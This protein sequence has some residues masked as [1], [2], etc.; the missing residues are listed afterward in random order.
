MGHSL[1]KEEQA[2]VKLLQHILSKRGLQYD[3]AALQRLLKWS[4]DRGFIPTVQAAF[5]ISE[6]ERIGQALSD[7]ISK[8]T[9]DVQN[10]STL[11]R[12]MLETLKEMKSERTAMASVLMATAPSSEQSGSGA[13]ATAMAFAPP[14]VPGT[15]LKH[16]TQTTGKG[17]LR[18]HLQNASQTTEV[19]ARAPDPEERDPESELDPGPDSP[20]AE[21]DLYPPLSDS[22][23]ESDQ[24]I[25]SAHQQLVAGSG[26][27]HQSILQRLAA[28]EAGSKVAGTSAPP[29]SKSFLK[30]GLVGMGPWDPLGVIIRHIVGSAYILTPYDIRLLAQ[31][32]LVPHLQLWFFN[33][34]DLACQRVASQPRQPG[35]PLLGVTAD[36]LLGKA[37]YDDPQTQANLPTAVLALSQEQALK[38]WYALPDDKTT[39]GFLS[40]KQGPTESYQQ[41][42]DRLFDA[43]RKHPDL[44]DEMKGKLLDIV[45]FDGA[46]D[47]T[48]QILNTLPRGRSTAQLLEAVDRM[49][50]KQK[51]AYMAEAFAAAIQPFTQKKGG[52]TRDKKCYN[53]GKLGHI[54]AQCRLK[55]ASNNRAISQNGRK[56]CERCNK[57]THNTVNCKGSGNGKSNAYPRAQTKMQ[58]AWTASPQPQPVVPEWTWQPQ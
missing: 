29:S 23:S 17:K 40:V 47:Q 37:Q 31:S 18:R 25:C 45:A 33:K 21:P 2:V 16:S 13:D 12:L 51:A 49:G 44:S 20:E 43:L 4:H 46:N 41:F 56:W 53:C 5:A 58:G 22:D 28:L 30:G 35:D 1:S 9:K 54:R 55:P 6:W 48:K 32:L 10:H 19:A 15:I 36:V 24:S 26:D 42:I 38:A 7:E 27:K 11:W 14:V 52:N 39:P 57:P 34:W 8:G 3:S 50:H